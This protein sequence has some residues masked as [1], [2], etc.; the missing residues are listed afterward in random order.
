MKKKISVGSA[1]LMCGSLFLLN[2]CV[3]ATPQP[4]PEVQLD[5]DPLSGG[6]S[7]ADIRTVA[8][9]MTPAILATPEISSAGDLA[10]IKISGFRN[11]TRF[12]IDNKLF[13]KRLTMELNRYGRGKVRFIND[14]A[15]VAIDRAKVLKDRQSAMVM[16]SLAVE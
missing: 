2:G 4:H 12:F 7:S 6:L 3:S 1:L 13:M 9:Q 11:N 14:D 5:S 16:D 15:K 8:T 10:K